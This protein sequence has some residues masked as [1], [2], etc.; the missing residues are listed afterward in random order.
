MNF[1][2]FGGTGF[3]GRNLA[4]YLARQGHSVYVPSKEALDIFDR[5][6]GHVIYAIGL[7][8][9]FRTRPFDTVEAHV[10]LLARLLKECRFDSWLY[11]SSTRVYSSL[12]VNEPANED[13]PIVLLPNADSLYDISKLM[14]E[15]LCLSYPSLRVRV[16]RLSNVY[17]EGQ[18]PHTFLAA[19]L[20]EL[21]CNGHVVVNETPLSGKDYVAIEDVLPIIESIALDGQK[22]V[23]NVASGRVITHAE[24]VDK[25]VELT[26]ANIKFSNNAKTRVFPPI[27][28]SRIRTEFGHQQT[29]LLDDL[30]GLLIKF[31]I[32][33]NIGDYT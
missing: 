16:A 29:I 32:N 14:G 20:E 2:I 9:D 24:L 10:C 18:S 31:G 3:V 30:N 22:R 8:G 33:P 21:K 15:S 7:T 1:T 5:D 19:I 6:L 17:G 28:T 12:N 27:D 23:Y 25:I 11:L 4:E 26:G 13:K